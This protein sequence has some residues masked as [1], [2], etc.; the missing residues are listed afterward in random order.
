MSTPGSK[1][2]EEGRGQFECWSCHIV[3]QKLSGRDCEL[4]A[5]GRADGGGGVSGV[6]VNLLVCDAGIL[7]YSE[8]RSHPDLIVSINEPEAESKEKHGVW[9][10][11][12]E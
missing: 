4:S 2:I 11:M 7:W 3:N 1:S 8:A 12:L 10:P 9:K 6:T 5:D